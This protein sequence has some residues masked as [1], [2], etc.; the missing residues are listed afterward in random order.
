MRGENYAWVA[1]LAHH[2]EECPSWDRVN[3][4]SR[5]VEKLDQ[6]TRYEWQGACKLTLVATTQVDRHNVFKLLKVHYFHDELFIMLAIVF[7]D[8]LQLSHIV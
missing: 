3:S 2:F 4:R 5:F 6:G 7:R 8:A 1:E